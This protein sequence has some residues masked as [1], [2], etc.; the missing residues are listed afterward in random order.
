MMAQ[1]LVLIPLAPLLAAVL[2][3]LLQLAGRMNG[4]AAEKVTAA[5]AV[6]AIGLSSLAASTA[7]IAGWLH[8]ERLEVHHY[9]NWLAIGNW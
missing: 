8:P 1:L 5:I 4:D 2:L 9:G 3:A 6:S 7:L